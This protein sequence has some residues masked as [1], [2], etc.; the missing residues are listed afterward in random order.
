[1]SFLNKSGRRFEVSVPLAANGA[2]L[3]G[4]R[5]PLTSV[6]I[7]FLLRFKLR[8]YLKTRSSIS[9]VSSDT[10]SSKSGTIAFVEAE[11]AVGV[12][13]VVFGDLS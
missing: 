11:R 2:R 8:S 12:G 6:Q 13:F 9:S 10:V 7:F 5:R 3:L 4:D 1:M